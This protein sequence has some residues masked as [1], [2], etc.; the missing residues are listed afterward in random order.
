L[1]TNQH[2]SLRTFPRS[3]RQTFGDCA[4]VVNTGKTSALDI[5]AEAI[6]EIV[7]KKEQPRFSYKVPHSI[8]TTGLLYR[9]D[10][11]ELEAT[12]FEKTAKA[13][14]GVS[15]TPIPLG[16]TDFSD[17]SSGRAYYVYFGKVEYRDVFGT[18]HWTQFCAW[19][20]AVK[21]LYPSKRCT[22]YNRADNN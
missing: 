5:A 2:C 14:P 20:A 21:G 9:D 7:P 3:S 15:Y 11:F 18:K 8:K 17:L 22:A 4:Q 6:L 10:P 12:I 13:L 19:S 1:G 16:Q